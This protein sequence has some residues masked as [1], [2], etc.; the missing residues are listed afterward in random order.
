[1]GLLFGPA[2]I[3]VT[4][5]DRSTEAGIKKVKEL[6]LG[7][8]EIEFVRG[9]NMSA[10]KARKVKEIATH[11]QIELTVHGPYFINLNSKEPDKVRASKIRILD[12]AKIGAIAGAKSV[13]FHAAYYGK[14]KLSEVYRVVRDALVEITETLHNENVKIDIRPETT[15]KGSQ[16]GTLDEILSLSHEVN[17]V[18]PCIDFAHIYAREGGKWN[19]YQEFM[20]LLELV[21]TE[22]GTTALKDMHIHISGMQYGPKGEKMHLTFEDKESKFNYKELMRALHEK[23]VEGFIICESPTLEAD[24]LIIKKLYESY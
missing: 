8:M 3:P 4:A 7:C 6:G 9:V 19:S 24:A 13:T 14:D 22:L 20:K 15:G 2:G 5:K 12:S 23:K 18:K 21:E 10:D 11:E 17:G 1:M 16:F